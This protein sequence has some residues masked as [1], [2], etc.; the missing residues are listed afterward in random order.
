MG[1]AVPALP[2]YEIAGEVMALEG[3]KGRGKER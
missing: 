2:D 1:A 3:K